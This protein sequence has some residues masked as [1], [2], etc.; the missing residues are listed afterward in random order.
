M[1]L[2]LSRMASICGDPGDCV[3]VIHTL[4]GVENKALGRENAVISGMLWITATRCGKRDA[5]QLRFQRK[6]MRNYSLSRAYQRVV[7]FLEILR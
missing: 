4:S 6:T 7:M 1:A 5:T 2:D 3:R